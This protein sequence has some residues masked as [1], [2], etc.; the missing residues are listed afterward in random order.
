MNVLTTIETLKI[1][2]FVKLIK[3]LFKA[4]LLILPFKY[5]L[6]FSIVSIVFMVI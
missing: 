5:I 3:G 4:R 2:G 6:S 1:T